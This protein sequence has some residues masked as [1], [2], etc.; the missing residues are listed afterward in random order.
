MRRLMIML[1][2]LLAAG[3]LALAAGTVRVGVLSDDVPAWQEVASRAAGQGLT[4]QVTGYSEAALYQKVYIYATFGLAN[5]DVVE[6]PVEW[7][8]QVLGRLLDLSPY[9]AGL[10][11][12]GAELYSYAGKTI[13]VVLPW[14]EDVFAAVLARSPNVGPALE[15]LPL[16]SR[17]QPTSPTVTTTPLQIQSPLAAV[18][19]KLGTITVPKPETALPGVDGSLQFLS[20]AMKQVMPQGLAVPLA[21]APE[22]VR[23]AIT[24]VAELFGIPLSPDGTSVQLVVKTVGGAVPLG[25]GA[26]EEARS[27]SGLSLVKV[28]LS[29]LGAFLSSMAGRAIVR[30]PYIPIPL[31][32]SEGAD[33]VGAAAFHARGFTGAGVKIG[34][35][36]LGFAGLSQLQA[37]GDL[38]TSVITRDFTGTG[39]E[40]GYHHGTAVAKIVHD[41]APDAELILIKIGNEVD[42]DN[43]VSYCIS[44]GVDIINHSLGWYNT[45]FYDGSGTIGDMVRRATSAG[46]LWVQAAGNSALKHWEGMFTDTNSD[47]WLDTDISFTAQAGK[48]ILLYLTWDGWPQTSDDYDLYLYGPDG[49]VVASSTKTQGGSQEPTERIY[50]TAPATG[51]YH[52]KI[53]LSSGSPKRLELFS[54]YQDLTP[55]I[56]ASSIPAPGNAAEALTVAAIDWHNYA[57]GPAEDF[58]S[59]GPTNDGRHKPDLS[60]PDNVTTGVQYYSPF[61]GTS[62]AAPHAAG[63]AALLLSEDPSLTLSE[64]RARLLSQCTAMG[65]PDTYGAGRLEASPQGPAPQPD[66]AIQS[67]TYSPT[68]PTVGSTLNFRITVVNQGSEA[69]G[70]FRVRI[71]GIGPAAEASL[72]SL[73]AGAS[74][75]VDLS[76]PLSTSPET[77]TATADPYGQVAESNENNNTRQITVTGQAALVAEAGGP[78]SGQV[79]QLITFDGRGSQGSIASYYWE[80]GDGAT[81]SG[82]VVQHAY[83]APGTYTVRLTVR[84]SVGHSASDTAQVTVT[85]APKPDLVIQNLTY[86]P[87]NPTVGTTLTFQITVRNQGAAPAGQFYVRLEGPA[88]H[89][90]AYFS[91]LVAGQSRTVTLSLALTGSP[92]TFTATADYLNQVVE[93]DETN[94][95][96]QVTVTAATPALT[97]TL[98]LD[99]SSYRVGD[100]VRIT[101]G[102]SRAAYVYLV[103][104]D[105]SGKATLIFPNHWEPDPRLP[106]GTT[107]LPRGT[108]YSILASQPT[109]SE[110]LYGFASESPIPYFP[111]GFPSTGFPVLSTN[112]SAFIATVRSWLSGHVPSGSWAE[113][114]ANFTVEPQANQPPVADFSYSPAHPTTGQ[115]IDFDASA[116]H[117]PDGHIVDYRWSFGDGTTA[118]GAH[119]TKRYTSP[120]TYTVRLTVRDDHGATGIATKTITVGAPANQPPVADFSYS[121]TH[122][123]PGQVVSF[124]ASASHDPDGSIVEYRWSFGDGATASGATVTHSYASA[125]SYTVELTVRDNSGATDTKTATIQVGTSSSLPGMPVIDKPG[126][127]VWGTDKWHITVAGSSSWSS[128]RKFQ[129]VLES[130]G[131]FTHLER[132]PAGSPP[133][134]GSRIVWTGTVGSG[135]VDLAFDLTGDTLMKLWL[136]LDTDGDGDPK[137][138][139]KDAKKIVFL[140]TCKTNPPGNPFAIYAPRGATALLPGMNFYIS[141][142]YS[143][144]RVSPVHWTIEYREKQAGCK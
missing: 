52:V 55:H 104:L 91:G 32:V 28:P 38:P 71:A 84:D 112:G 11:S 20:Q 23:E 5:L 83:S 75:T 73:A 22:P 90:N 8:P 64:L 3:G 87:A 17:S 111:T 29:Q 114:H 54:I 117:D 96:R 80:F 35:I 39:I 15:L 9:A 67:I 78:Y 63:V 49:S 48:N 62:A 37:S 36:D 128:P 34:I 41:I 136:Y 50:T 66:L 81:A 27:P 13:G 105:S 65:D 130:R 137:P 77:F 45:N 51:T 102:L 122:P 46:I 79:G 21:S 139:A 127:Y 53:Q 98:A 141:V 26:Q 56:A 42:L 57:T 124:D 115:W 44:Q 125:G 108:A 47:G 82:A 12:Q 74:Y 6:V 123:D 129:V 68:S 40:T 144:G 138:K 10:E 118:S 94:N 126:I 97:L 109:G 116:S 59:R 31:V 135:W 133:A 106:G 2:S 72:S 16:V 95:T 43:A 103:E 134:S 107:V 132:T 61:P 58:S 4:V 89:R 7:L 24:Q 121:P 92:Q 140:R 30:P 60:A 70:A 18:G 14:R 120:G 100:P 93:S 110:T 69:A 113:A 85:A 76:L 88:G 1:I 142:V 143:D 131:I 33:L 119:V 19:L 25:A 99:R 101:V 86:T